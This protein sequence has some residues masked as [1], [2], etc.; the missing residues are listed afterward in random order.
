MVKQS[1]ILYNNLVPKDQYAFIEIPIIPNSIEPTSQLFTTISSQAGDR[2]GYK[3]DRFGNAT[4]KCNEIPKNLATNT[5]CHTVQLL[6]CPITTQ[7]S[8]LLAGRNFTRNLANFVCTR[9]MGMI[10]P[11][12]TDEIPITVVYYLHE[13]KI[14]ADDPIRK[15]DPLRSREPCVLVLVPLTTTSEQKD[16]LRTAFTDMHPQDFFW[17]NISTKIGISRTIMPGLQLEVSTQLSNI[18]GRRLCQ[19]YTYNFIEI[20][21]MQPGL[22][23]SKVLPALLGLDS[24]LLIIFLA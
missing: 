8:V 9:L 18:H 22:A 21:G 4:R 16:Q 19:H 6:T 1:E 13:N 7:A 5:I 20:S 3:L 12:S 2:F 17:E 11:L 24:H 23:D 14:K 15:D 10:H